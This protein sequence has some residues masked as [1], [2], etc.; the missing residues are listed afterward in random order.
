[1]KSKKKLLKK[2]RKKRGWLKWF[3]I[4][5]GLMIIL[6]TFFILKDIPNPKKLSTGDYP[7]STQILDRSGNLLYEIYAEKNRTSVKL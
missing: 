2:N 1:M 7:E 5:G 3:L 6:G 4:V